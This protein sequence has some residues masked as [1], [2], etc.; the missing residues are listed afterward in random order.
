MNIIGYRHL[1][2]LR[3]DLRD[4]WRGLR[5]DPGFTVVA[6]AIVAAMLTANMVLFAFLDAFFLRRLPIAAAERHF[7]LSVQ[8]EQGRAQRSWPLA[9]VE[10]FLADRESVLETGYAFA[11]RRVIVGDREQRSYVEVVTP[12]YFELVKPRLAAGRLPEGQEASIL[13]SDSGWKRL[14]G[15]DPNAIGTTLMVN[16]VAV[17]IVGRLAEGAGGL[18]PVTP[19]FWMLAGAV[20]GH[21]SRHDSYSIGG[22]L[23]EGISAEQASAALA[24]AVRALDANSAQDSAR[25]VLVEP[26]PTFLR[27]RREL[28]PAALSILFLFGLVTLIAG[29]NLTSLHLARA[30]ARRRDL[31]IRVA[32]GASRARLIRHILTESV[33]LAGIAAIAAWAISLFSIASLQGFVFSIVSDAGMSVRSIDV[34]ARVFAAT[35]LLAAL[36]GAGCA[37]TPALHVTRGSLEG[38]LR[39][40]ARWLSGRVSAGRLRGA[41]V[42]VQIALSLPLLVGAGILVRSVAGV[43]R[44]DAGFEIDRL[45]DL[46]ADPSSARVFA[47]MRDVPGVTAIGAAANTPLTGPMARTSARVAGTMMPVGFNRVDERFFDTVGIRVTWGRNFHPHETAANAPVAIISQATAR[48]LFAE[49]NPLGRSMELEGEGGQFRSHEIVGIAADVISGLF[50][51]GHDATA[52]YVPGN[53][54][55]GASEILLRVERAGAAELTGLRAACADVGAFCEPYTLRRVLSMQRVPFVVSSAVAV[56]LGL[57]A[58]GLACLGLHGLARFSVVQRTREFG[59]RFALGATR[60]NVL[61]NV[62][63]E[64]TRRSAWGIALG[65]PVSLAISALLAAKVPFLQS[66]DVLSYF[67]VPCILLV[68]ALLATLAPALRAAAIDPITALREE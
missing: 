15:S 1:D 43:N 51:Q 65:L 30:V 3:A 50:I 48:R 46:R 47:R 33:L 54:E 24:P 49:G 56:S 14:T 41:L 39:R 37:L 16:G 66:F 20:A 35:L 17:T 18:E 28:Q 25:R 27:E 53:L 44:M 52:V 64:S 38:A 55:S 4:A 63:A 61:G 26:R 8:D 13:L 45:V 60:A 5:R 36:V 19:D 68:C 67:L 32:L 40:D 6:V 42:M 10:R 12:S 29:A 57:L 9:D 62:L 22:V 11:D 23:R 58:L 7:E 21:A 59:V 31:A 2:S 34:D